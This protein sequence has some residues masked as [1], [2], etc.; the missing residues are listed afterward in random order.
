MGATSKFVQLFRLVDENDEPY[1]VKQVNGKPRV[2]SMPYLFDIAEGNVSGH[3]LFE[4]YAINDDVD[5]AAEEDVWCVGGSYTWPTGAINVNLTSSSAEDDPAK[6]D[7]SAGT[8]IWSVRLYYLT[9]AF[10]EK[11]VDVTLNGTS[12]VA[13][14][15]GDIYRINRIRPLTM[16]TALKAVGNIDAHSTAGATPIYS[17]IAAGFT[18]GRQ[19]VYT[20]PAGKTLYITDFTGSIGGATA[21]KYGRFTLRSTWDNI[22]LTRNA[23]FTAYAECGANSGTFVREFLCPIKIG[24]KSDVIVS[25]KTVDND[26]YVTA[27]IRGWLETN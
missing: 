15:V 11:T 18:K 17:R 19:L 3:T 7:T 27:A 6:A 14:T 12:S 13:T 1:G 5:S 9:T 16:G 26:C 2:S 20:V 4:K 8:G 25:C 21:P 10:A 24:E 22:G 23:W